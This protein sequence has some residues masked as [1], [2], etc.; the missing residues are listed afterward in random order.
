MTRK[1]RREI[2]AQVEQLTSG[3]ST[4][5]GG[6]ISPELKEDI[7][8]VLR[9]RY[10]RGLYVDDETQAQLLCSAYTDGVEQGQVTMEN[11][12]TAASDIGIGHGRP[13]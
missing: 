4:P 13:A 12:D 10:S 2:E 1:S 5:V 3:A 8:T 9:F 6:D 7:R 11:L